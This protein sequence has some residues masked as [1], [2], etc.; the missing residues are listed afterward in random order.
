MS[1]KGRGREG[2]LWWVSRDDH[3]LS[4]QSEVMGQT[5]KLETEWV[6]ECRGL[7]RDNGCNFVWIWRWRVTGLRCVCVWSRR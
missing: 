3:G 7:V 1:R 6:R 4:M 2:Y 5:L